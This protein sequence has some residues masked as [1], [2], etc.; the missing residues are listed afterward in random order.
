MTS[1]QEIYN[2]AR[3]LH[4]SIRSWSFEEQDRFF[5]TVLAAVAVDAPWPSEVMGEFIKKAMEDRNE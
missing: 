1:D 3:E 5:A 2:L 4:R